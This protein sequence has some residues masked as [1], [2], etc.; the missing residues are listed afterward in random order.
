MP[1]LASYLNVKPKICSLCKMLRNIAAYDNDKN[2]YQP[3]RICRFCRERVSRDKQRLVEFR[4][5]RDKI[6]QDKIIEKHIQT[7]YQRMRRQTR[8]KRE[9]VALLHKQLV[10]LTNYPNK[11]IKKQQTIAKN[12]AELRRWHNAYA[13][14]VHQLKTTGK[15]DH[16]LDAY[17]Q[18]TG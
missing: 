6:A 3:F 1:K 2:P 18:V 14:Q 9:Y 8:I 12:E 13:L 16:I 15:H 5:E 7:L 17:N 11:I 4:L 10:R